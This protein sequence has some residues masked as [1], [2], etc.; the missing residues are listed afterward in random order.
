M[1]APR[2]R[3]GA[4]E[5]GAAAATPAAASRPVRAPLL[6]AERL[7]ALVDRLT[8][9]DCAGSD[10]DRDHEQLAAP[11]LLGRLLKADGGVA[12]RLGRALGAALEAAVAGQPARLAPLGLGTAQ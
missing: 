11:V 1:A 6:G 3:A 12:Q 10:D 5:A 7:S 4:A 2:R 8:G 9:R